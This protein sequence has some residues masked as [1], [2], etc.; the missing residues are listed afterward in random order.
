MFCRL[1]PYGRE[2]QRVSFFSPL[3]DSAPL[4]KTMGAEA[5]PPFS[6][7]SRARF[8][9]QAIRFLKSGSFRDKRKEKLR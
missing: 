2:R 6:G 1:G 7:G 5:E 4:R 3:H 8:S 9:V